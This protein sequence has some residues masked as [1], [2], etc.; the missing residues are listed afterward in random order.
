MWFGG[1]VSTEKVCQTSPLKG[2]PT[3]EQWLPLLGRV[4][5]EGVGWRADLNADRTLRHCDSQQQSEEPPWWTFG[6]PCRWKSGQTAVISPL[7]L[8]MPGPGRHYMVDRGSASL[9]CPQRSSCHLSGWMRCFISSM[10]APLAQGSPS[11]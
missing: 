8:K 2:F 3:L 11:H 7:L 10:V 9:G 6:L 5:A 4:S 1:T